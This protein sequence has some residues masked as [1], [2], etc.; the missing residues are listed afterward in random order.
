MKLRNEQTEIHD[1][2]LQL[3]EPDNTDV[4]FVFAYF[5]TGVTAI[6]KVISQPDDILS[7]LG[8]SQSNIHLAIKDLLG[9]SQQKKI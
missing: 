8:V 7:R 4:G 3:A 6:P 1:A 2:F 9:S 5:G